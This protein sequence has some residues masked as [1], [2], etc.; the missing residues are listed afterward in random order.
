MTI[1]NMRTK[2]I[3]HRNENK[4]RKIV[5][6]KVSV[7]YIENSCWTWSRHFYF[8]SFHHNELFLPLSFMKMSISC[9]YWSSEFG[10]LLS[11]VHVYL[12]SILKVTFS[13]RNLKNKNGA[14]KFNRSSQCNPPILL[15]K[16]SFYI[17]SHFCEIWS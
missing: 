12:L 4:Y 10:S 6:L 1:L 5:W 2:I 9:L 17:Y 7:D 13:K 14:I 16:R 11:I 8:L 15:T 3:F